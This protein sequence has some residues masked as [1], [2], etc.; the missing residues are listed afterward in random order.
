MPAM[1]K[2]TP[3]KARTAQNRDKSAFFGI[4]GISAAG[5]VDREC[6]IIR[7]FRDVCK[8]GHFFKGLDTAAEKRDKSQKKFFDGR[9]KIS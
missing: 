6:A 9:P 2:C 8:I 4:F 1:V 7:H 3:K 5:A